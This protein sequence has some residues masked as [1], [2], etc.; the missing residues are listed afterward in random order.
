MDN[1]TEWQ[2]KVGV[3]ERQVG[4]GRAGSAIEVP[5]YRE[6]NGELGGKQTIHWDGHEDCTI[7]APTIVHDGK[8]G[9]IRS[10]S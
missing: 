4:Q 2:K 3:G 8:A 9:D 5:I 6:D 7:I 1:R 10:S